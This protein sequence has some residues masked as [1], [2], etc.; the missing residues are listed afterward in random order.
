MKK[1]SILAVL[2]A[3]C[4]IASA[5]T[6]N[7]PSSLTGSDALAGQNAY[8]WGIPITLAAGQSITTASISFSDVTLTVANASGKGYLYT[9]LLNSSA[10]GVHTYS[11]GD[12]SGDYFKT[13]YSSPNIVSLGTAYFSRVGKTLNWTYTFDI[14]ELAA[15]NSFL[16]GGIFDIGF[17]PD[18]HYTVGNICFNYTT[19]SVPDTATT[20]YMLGLG[21]LA[22]EASR[23]KFA[24]VKSK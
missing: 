1:I 24:A 19:T 23:R 17:D 2:A 13:Q 21:L 6:I 3:A 18:C 5:V 15:L 22:L 16:A 10:T 12:A 7:V 20:V 11:D 14:A 9:D 4:S 8:S